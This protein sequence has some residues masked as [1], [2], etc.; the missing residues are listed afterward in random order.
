MRVCVTRVINRL[1]RGRQAFT[2]CLLLA[3]IIPSAVLIAAAQMNNAGTMLERGP[4]I[5]PQ[6]QAVVSTN[7]LQAPQEAQTAIHQARDAQAR[8]RYAEARGHIAR[9]LEVYP[10]YALA[11][12]FR[13]IL[14][15]RENHLEEACSDFQQAI[16]YHPNLRAAYLS[17]GAVDNQLCH[18][19]YA[20][21]AL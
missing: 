11:L 20:A 1:K 9:A 16:A 15:L 18:L 5:P 4:A 13:G 7:E 10:K 6:H 14:N 21:L 3:A 12:E 19:E 8:G 17:L 2:G